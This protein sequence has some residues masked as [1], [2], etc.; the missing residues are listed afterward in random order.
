M[1]LPDD[2]DDADSFEDSVDVEYGD[3]KPVIGDVRD[4]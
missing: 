2:D 1:Y 4:K 3:W